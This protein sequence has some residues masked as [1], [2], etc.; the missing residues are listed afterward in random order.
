MSLSRTC[1]YI[2]FTCKLQ[3]N[4]A[5]PFTAR[6]YRTTIILFHFFIYLMNIMLMRCFNIRLSSPRG[7]I[8]AS[9]SLTLELYETMIHQ[10]VLGYKLHPILKGLSLQC[11]ALLW[12]SVDNSALGITGER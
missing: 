6:E 9:K 12:A 5:S 7:R 8:F 2:K 4:S 3:H 10:N 11:L 1:F